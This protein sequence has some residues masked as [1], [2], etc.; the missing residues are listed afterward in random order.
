MYNIYNMYLYTILEGEREEK[1][2][3]F[4]FSSQDF[5]AKPNDR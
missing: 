4:Y 3:E 1:K 5:K 2:G